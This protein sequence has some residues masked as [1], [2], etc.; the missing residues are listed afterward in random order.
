MFMGEW[1]IRQKIVPSLMF[2]GEQCGRAE[3]AINFYR[4]V[5]ENTKVDHIM[6][7]G[8]GEEPEK[9]GTVKH[10]DFTLEGQQFAAMDSARAHNFSFNE[11]I[12]FIVPCRTQDEIDRYWGKLSAHPNAEQCGWLKDKFGLSWQVVPTVLN[13]LLSDADPNRTARVTQAFLKMKKFDIAKL[14]EAY[15][16]AGGSAA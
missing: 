3:E 8:N 12:S 6:R 10:A 16:Q 5:F 7:Y 15:A 4:S 14:E 13:E 1:P 9:E 11:A 2:V